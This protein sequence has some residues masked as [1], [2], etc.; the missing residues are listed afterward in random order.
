[1]FEV[2][3]SAFVY[4]KAH[5]RFGEERSSSG[6]PIEYDSY[7]VR[8]PPRPLSSDTLTT[9]P[10]RSAPGIRSVIIAHSTPT[11]SPYGAPTPERRVGEFVPPHR[12]R[13]RSTVRS[14]PSCWSVHAARSRE[15]ELVA[16][17]GP[18]DT[19]GCCCVVP[20]QQVPGVEPAAGRRRPV[21]L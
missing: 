14:V 7:R 18:I 20:R 3:V 21:Q 13:G 11:T 5:E 19:G 1:M 10:K 8:C 2:N 17:I 4:A 12:A 6:D 16:S 15:Y 9:C